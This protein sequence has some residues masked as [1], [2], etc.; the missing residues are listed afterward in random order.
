MFKPLARRFN[1]RTPIQMTSLTMMMKSSTNLS[2]RTSIR[3]AKL[4]TATD[5]LYARLYGDL[6][7]KQ[8]AILLLGHLL[9]AVCAIIRAQFLLYA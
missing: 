2:R 3:R 7:L 8:L 1:T 4:Q 6:K 5:K 9:N